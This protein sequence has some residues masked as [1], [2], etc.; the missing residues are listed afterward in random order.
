MS[1]DPSNPNDPVRVEDPWCDPGG[2]IGMGIGADTSA[3]EPSIADIESRPLRE[4]LMIAAPTVVTMTSH[5]VMQYVDAQMVS[6]I[7]PEPVYVA[8]QGNGGM[9]AWLMIALPMGI[10]AVLST[11]VSQNLGAGKPREG[12]AYAWNA[13]WICVAGWLALML[14]AMIL[15]PQLF[16]LVAWFQTAAAGEGVSGGDPRLGPMQTRYAQV[17]L[18][19][20]FLILGA[21]TIGHYFF[22]LHR[23]V[24]VMVG[25]IAGNVINVGA[26]YVLI[27]GAF[28]VEPMGVTGAA[29]GT[30]IGSLV[31][32]GVPMVVFLSPFYARTFSTRAAWRVSWRH[33]R[34]LIKIGWPSG[35]MIFNE[36]MC[37]T[38][39]MTVL[40]AAG[41]AAAGEDPETHNAAGWIGL[42]YMHL[43]FMPTIGLSIA[44]SAIVGKCMGMGRPDLAESRAWLGLRIAI[45]YMG[46]C[47]VGFFVFRRDLVDLFVEESATPEQREALVS[48]GARVMIAAAV[49]QV[50]DACAV[51]L[52]A[53]LRGAGDTVWPGVATIVL[54][55]VGVVGIGHLMIWQ[56]PGLGSIGPWIGGAAY[57]T[58]LGVLLLIRFWAGG[59]KRIRLVDGPESD[60]E[61]PGQ[62]GSVPA[63]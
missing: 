47:A 29:I 32:F 6:R 7:G 8:A 19:G 46:L 33:L 27:F 49:F 43:S 40:L 26:N 28:G 50:F 36:L 24:V 45:I 10:T 23:P 21:R 13:L 61:G 4:M 44:V 55:W 42:R 34:D 39:L 57:I 18:G 62:S 2:E 20:G 48:V 37:W 25:T 11:F 58:L 59:W 35:A 63:A 9:V 5:T 51:T 52:S 31:E 60:P 41:G 53:A 38:Y 16:D 56:A 17:L 1:V 3:P 54:S 15:S 14:P 30:I 22:G 12:A